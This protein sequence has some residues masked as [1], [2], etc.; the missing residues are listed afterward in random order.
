MCQLYAVV[1]ISIMISYVDTTKIWWYN[2]NF[3]K[4][5]QVGDV[6]HHVFATWAL[7]NGDWYMSSK[8]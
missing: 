4:C 2:T 7:I 1:T 3:L 6:S 8:I 5:H